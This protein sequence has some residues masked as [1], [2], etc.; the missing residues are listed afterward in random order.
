MKTIVL[1]AIVALLASTP[2]AAQKLDLQFEALAAKAKQ[3]TELNLD[4]LALQALR[5]PPGM[6][7]VEG[8]VIRHY[9]FATGGEYAASDLEPLRRQLGS[10]SGWSRIIAVKDKND[11]VEIYIFH[12][13]EKPGGFLLIA[14]EPKELSVV[15][16]RGSIPLD[17]LKELVSSSIRYDLKTAAEEK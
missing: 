9:E 3:K 12:Q 16:V 11:D 5:N 17:Q 13:G 2:A 8:V 6:A 1:G 7:T 14:A 4:G 15:Y 10:G